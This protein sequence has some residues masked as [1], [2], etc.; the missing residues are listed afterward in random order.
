MAEGDPPVY[1]L[2]DSDGTVQAEI[3][4]DLAESLIIDQLQGNN[5]DFQNSELSNIASV[6]T[7]E[8]STTGSVWQELS[9]ERDF[10]TIYQAPDYDIEISPITVATTDGTEIRWV[11]EVGE[12]DDDLEGASRVRQ[13]VDTDERVKSDGI[14]VPANHF[15]RLRRVGG[16]QGDYDINLWSELR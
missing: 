13:T 2:V 9:D 12:S 7:E 14:K 6:S 4:H 1:Q 15:Y 10:E 16:D 8:I 11:L 3:R 5:I